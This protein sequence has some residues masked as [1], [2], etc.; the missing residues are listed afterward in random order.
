MLSRPLLAT[1]T[2]RSWIKAI[3][4]ERF[5]AFSVTQNAT[6]HELRGMDTLLVCVCVW[7]GGGGGGGGGV[8]ERGEGRG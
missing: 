3:H 6:L 1:V 5:S 2:S 8:E 7:G 4:S